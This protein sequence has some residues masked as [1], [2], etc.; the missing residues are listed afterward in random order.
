MLK[1][2]GQRNTKPELVIIRTCEAC[3]KQV[4]SSYAINMIFVVGSPGHPE[5]APFQCEHEEHWAC[6]LGCW[7]VVAHACID[8]HM[9]E[10]LRMKHEEKGIISGNE[11]N[12]I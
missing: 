4:D 12:K 8:E 9:H 10:I 5:L 11:L 1:P 7:R 3:G 6:S 2:L